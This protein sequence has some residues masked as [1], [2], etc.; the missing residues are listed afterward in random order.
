MP[1]YVVFRSQSMTAI[2]ILAC[3]VAFPSMSIHIFQHLRSLLDNKGEFVAHSTSSILDPF[4]QIS[5]YF[6][7]WKQNFDYNFENTLCD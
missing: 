7:W 2:A 6:I 3:L 5:L 4:G 1:C